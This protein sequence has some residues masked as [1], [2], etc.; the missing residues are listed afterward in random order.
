M[1]DNV[2]RMEHFFIDNKQNSREKKE[3]YNFI[4]NNM[5]MSICELG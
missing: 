4:M 1:L 5:R 2:E 3:K